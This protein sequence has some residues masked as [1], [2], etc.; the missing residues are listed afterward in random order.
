MRKQGE[1]EVHQ[2]AH[3]KEVHEG[4]VQKV[5]SHGGRVDVKAQFSGLMLL[6]WRGLRRRKDLSFRESLRRRRQMLCSD[7][8]EAVTLLSG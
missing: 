6:S 3:G 5:G 8:Q 1:L 7:I 2:E 4:E